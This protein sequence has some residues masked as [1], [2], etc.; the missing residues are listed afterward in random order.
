MLKKKEK[1]VINPYL[2]E[3]DL[4]NKRRQIRQPNNITMLN[5]ITI[6]NNKLLI[7]I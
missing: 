1:E 7:E 5:K 3:Q 4:W 2:K 6:I